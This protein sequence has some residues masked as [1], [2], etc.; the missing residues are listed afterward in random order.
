MAICISPAEG[1]TRLD[2]G[3]SLFVDIRDPHSFT[4][5][6]VKGALSLTQ[7]NADAFL[8]DTPQDQPLVV[9]CYHG[10]SS[11]NAAQWLSEQGFTHVVS[12]DGG[13]EVFNNNYPE[14]IQH[15]Q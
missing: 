15:D 13:F 1:K 12:L 10:I 9:Y 5:G 14:D 7:A 11:Q 6:H 2:S 8:A 4:A 3:D